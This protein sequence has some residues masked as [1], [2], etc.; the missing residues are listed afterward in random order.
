MRNTWFFIRKESLES[1]RSYHLLIIAIV[2]IIFG[3]EGPLMAKLTPDIL[4]MASSSSFTIKMPDPTSIDAW[5]QYYKNMTQIGI[6]VLVVIF[7]GTVSGEVS[8]GTL[9][10]LVTKG[11][12]RYSIIIAK[13]F[14]AYMQ[15]CF[16]ILIT[17]LINWAYTAYYFPDNKTPNVWSGMSLLII[18]GL[19]FVAVTI[20][21]S[22]LSNSNYMGFLTAVV[23]F[24][25]LT[26]LNLFKEFKHYNP[27]ALVTD[28]MSL[29]KGTKQIATIMPAIWITI[30][31]SIVII[32]LAILILNKKRL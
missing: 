24:I 3:I 28:N 11:L 9:V 5:Q 1:L 6:F 27:I 18:F 16:A 21:G 12:S 2:F 31:S 32:Y 22:T 10:N 23:V 15:W 17:F 20:F 26:L 8:R 13:Y 29:I 19:M 30:V 25:I 4:K 14:V 7:S